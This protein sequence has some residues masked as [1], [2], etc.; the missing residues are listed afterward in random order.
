MGTL[1]AENK[2]GA[3]A[4]HPVRCHQHRGTEQVP[5][6]SSAPRVNGQGLFLLK[7]VKVVSGEFSPQMSTGAHPR[8]HACVGSAQRGLLKASYRGAR[9][10]SACTKLERYR[11]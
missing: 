1:Q 4:G 11:G 6:A 9:F 3:A 5:P 10:G 8:T 2:P 7:V